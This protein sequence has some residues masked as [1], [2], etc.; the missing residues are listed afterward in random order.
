MES[1]NWILRKCDFFGPSQ[2]S[3]LLLGPIENFAFLGPSFKIINLFYEFLYLLS[4]V[5]E[6]LASLA[7]LVNHIL[8]GPI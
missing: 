4:V 5:K 7:H 2:K 6:V 1:L 8:Q 3:Y